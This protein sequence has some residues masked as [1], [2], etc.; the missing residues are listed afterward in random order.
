MWCGDNAELHQRKLFQNLG[1]SQ[2]GEQ[3]VAFV[4]TISGTHLNI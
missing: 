2:K 3:L 1:I 4:C